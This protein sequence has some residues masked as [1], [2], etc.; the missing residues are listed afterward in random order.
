MMIK[1]DWLGLNPF[2]MK[3]REFK[4]FIR[5]HPG[6]EVL[7]EPKTD[8]SMLG[9]TNASLASYGL[10][11]YSVVSPLTRSWISQSLECMYL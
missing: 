6:E 7:L 10:M 11:T 4:W 2:M 5:D 3:L 9:Y 8:V 1:S